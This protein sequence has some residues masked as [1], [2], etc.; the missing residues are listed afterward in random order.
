MKN[1]VKEMNLLET[2][3]ANGSFKTLVRTLQVS[4]LI[5]ILRNPDISY[6]LFAP[7][8]KAFQPLMRDGTLQDLLK[9]NARLSRLIGYHIL[10]HKVVLAHVDGRKIFRT[11]TGQNLMINTV[12]N[13]LINAARVVRA[14]IDC[15]NGILH[16]IDAVLFPK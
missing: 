8:D 1:A 11:H 15:A 2:L 5:D 14:D 9:D 13:L 6:T 3:A 7:N 4:G 16:E 12:G 10:P